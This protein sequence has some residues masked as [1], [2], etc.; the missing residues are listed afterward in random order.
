MQTEDVV[1]N[2]NRVQFKKAL[3]G[4][5]HVKHFRFSLISSRMKKTQTRVNLLTRAKCS[6]HY[7]QP[8]MTAARL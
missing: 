7:A 4:A 5:E 2:V 3:D 8:S 6:T 1:V